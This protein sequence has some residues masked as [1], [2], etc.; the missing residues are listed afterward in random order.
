MSE[1]VPYCAYECVTIN[2]SV[3]IPVIAVEL[4]CHDKSLVT[5]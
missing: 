2:V 5:W 1:S 3:I 4:G